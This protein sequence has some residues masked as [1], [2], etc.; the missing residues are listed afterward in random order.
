MRG[1]DIVGAKNKQAIVLL[2]EQL[3]A[4]HAGEIPA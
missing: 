2:R 4:A 3:K 1:R